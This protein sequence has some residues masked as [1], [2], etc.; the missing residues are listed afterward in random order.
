MRAIERKDRDRQRER[1]RD[2]D[3]DREIESG[4]REGG[5]KNKD[6]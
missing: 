6:R 3:E 4:G 2:R 5:G 1:H